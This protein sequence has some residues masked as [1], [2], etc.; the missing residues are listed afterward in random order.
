[1]LSMSPIQFTLRADHMEIFNP[2]WNFSSVYQADISSWLN[3]K[4][5]LE[6]ALQL[7]VKISARYTEF[8]SQLGLANPRWNFNPGW[9]HHI[10]HIPIFPTWD[11][12]SWFTF[13]KNK[14]DASNAYFRCTDDKFISLIKCLQEFKSSIKFRNCE[15]NTDKV[16]LTVFFVSNTFF[17]LSLSVA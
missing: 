14:D 7:S 5:L 8:K 3:S 15:S 6:M 17:Q 13:R 10:F 4:L 2:V 12:N 9:K 16:K 1:M 11:K